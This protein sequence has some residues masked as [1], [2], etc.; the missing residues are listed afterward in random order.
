[1]RERLAERIWFGADVPAR[2]ARAA[3]APLGWIYGGASGLRNM[4]YDSGA[5]PARELA[6]PAV[7]IGN[8]TVG[9]TGKTPVAAE[10]ARRLAA[11][12][13]R[14]AIVLR[15]YG[16][17][18]PLVHERLNPGIVVVATPDRVAGAREARRRGADAVVLDDAFQ[19]RRAA[20]LA[21]IVL[22]SA[23]RWGSGRRHALPAGPWRE[24]LRALRRASLVV[25]T[26]KAA[27]D[28][29]VRTLVETCHR[30]AD[31]PVAVARLAPGGLASAGDDTH[32][33]VAALHD[34]RVLAIA[35]I[36]DPAA[37]L[38]QLG[39]LGA[40]VTPRIFGDHHHFARAEV[41]T[42]A[43]E[44]AA[45]DLVV[46]TLKD[47]VK[48]APLWPRAAPCLWYVSQ[49]VSFEA[50]EPDL[51]RLLGRLIDARPPTLT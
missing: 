29:V 38:R 37:F 49:A 16:G 18:E 34:A 30:V 28:A 31:V 42:L 8:L 39:A 45:H 20:R 3:L 2:L 46:C 27:D 19:H 10:V 7:S 1:M 15:G 40:R 44:A 47:A 43:R 12:G 9:G 32:R 41:T 36:G 13:A 6:L 21:D 23:D 25:V 5:L 22:L 51:D 48:L 17:D 50:G 33:P 14:P 24:S 4:L 26:R 35:A 11:R